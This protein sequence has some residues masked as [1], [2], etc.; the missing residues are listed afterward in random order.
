[1]EVYDRILRKVRGSMWAHHRRLMPERQ[2][3]RILGYVYSH[4]YEYQ[5][6]L[7]AMSCVGHAP[8]HV[9]RAGVPGHVRRAKDR[10]EN[11]DVQAGAGR[12][13]CECRREGFHGPLYA[14][15]AGL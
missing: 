8:H 10:V 7:D 12:F 2:F 9:E 4:K 3:Q 6:R 1:M 14:R 5:I 13:S 15:R 11:K